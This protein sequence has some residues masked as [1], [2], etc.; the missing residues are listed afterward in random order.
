MSRW[1]EE[2]E[3]KKSYFEKESG[4]KKPSK[5]FLGF[6]KIGSGVTKAFGR[7]DLASVN[8]NKSIK[9][10]AI[11]QKT[12]VSA[13]KTGENYIK[14]LEKA[15]KKETKDDVKELLEILEDDINACIADATSQYRNRVREFKDA[16]SSLSNIEVK[17]KARVDYA[18]ADAIIKKARLFIRMQTLSY[19]RNDFYNTG[20]NIA[21]AVWNYSQSHQ[22]IISFDDGREDLKKLTNNFFHF[23]KYLGGGSPSG[24][25]VTQEE[26]NQNID[27]IGEWQADINKLEVLFKSIKEKR[28][29]ESTE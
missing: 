1:R 5:T 26:I 6:F 11:F 23:T 21:E 12:I 3:Q 16:Q 18:K 19:N 27:K 2:W 15:V 17:K 29:S 13:K 22:S 20:K 9:H 14:V 28:K 8:A 10:L 25:E 4:R 7:M 24:K